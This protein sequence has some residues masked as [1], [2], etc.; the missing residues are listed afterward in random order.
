MNKHGC[1]S[2]LTVS[3]RVRY[4]WDTNAYWTLVCVQIKNK[5]F[6]LKYAS[7]WI[8]LKYNMDTVFDGSI[9]SKGPN[10]P[11]FSLTPKIK[12]EKNPNPT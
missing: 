5:F 6:W 8:Q 9:K 2:N 4:I 7:D 11:K 12:G 3:L 10:E 1:M